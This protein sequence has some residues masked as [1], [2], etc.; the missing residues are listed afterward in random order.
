MDGNITSGNG[1]QFEQLRRFNNPNL[2][3]STASYNNEESWEK[4][5]FKLT[6]V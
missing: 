6:E 1:N 5:S 2:Y 3:Y 4:N